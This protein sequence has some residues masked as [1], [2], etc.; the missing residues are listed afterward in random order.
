[1]LRLFSRSSNPFRLSPRW[2]LISYAILG[3]W[4]FIVLFPLYWLFV[5]SF[6]LPIDVSSGPKYIPFVDFQPSMHAWEEMLVTNGPDYVGRPYTITLI[7]GISSALLALAIG[8]GAAYAL[9]RFQYGP[10]PGLIVTFIGCVGFMAVIMSLGAPWQF[11]VALGLVLYF[12]LAQGIGRRFKGSMN[13]DDIA[14]WLISQRI[15]PPV[16]VIIPI[17]ILYQQLGMLD[18]PQALI[19]TYCA[20]NIP[21]VVWFMRDYFQSLPIELEESAFIDGANRFQVLRQIILPLSIPGLIATFL[22]I[23]VFSWNEYVMALFLSGSQTQTMPL[24]VSGQNGVRGPQWWNMSVL[25][26][27]MIAPLI[28]LAVVLE[29]YI[30]KGLLVGAVKG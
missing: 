4:A 13:N 11:A 8:A 28:F 10:K 30:A 19:V 12:L 20:A 26:A 3:L 1:M 7:V 17:Y 29:R 2:M 18:T 21:I 9:T 15:L 14:F 16:T 23:L 22:I 25:V 27:L 5:T 24:L 6:K